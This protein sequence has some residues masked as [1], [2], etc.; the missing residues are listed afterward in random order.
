MSAGTSRSTGG[1]SR[2]VY[3]PALDGVRALAVIVVLLFHAGVP[4]FDGGYLG[5]SVFFTLSGYLITSLLV[6]E[7]DQSGRIDL[8]AFYGR[9]MRRLLPASVVTVALIVVASW[10][11][12]WFEGVSNLRAHVLGSLFQVANWV[13]L[14][15]DGSY[16][17][18]LEESAGAS[19]PLE[20]FWSLA[21]E[22]QFYW[23]W[24]MVMLGAFAVVRGRRG[25]IV[26]VGAFTALSMVAAPFVAVVWG[27]DAAY[28]ATPA[29]LAEI[30]VGAL[31][32]VV[33]NERIVPQRAAALAPA[34]LVALGACVV[35]FPTAGGPAYSGAL[36]LIAVG[37]GALL[38]G[39][40][41]EGPVREVLS[42]GVLVWIG[43]VSYGIYLFHWPIYVVLDADRAGFDGVPLVLV[44]LALTVAIAAVSYYLFELPIRHTSRVEFPPTI[45]GAA[46]A[47]SVT[48]VAAVV[49]VP[50]AL[51]DYWQTDTDDVEAAAIVVDDTPLVPLATVPPTTVAPTTPPASV[52]PTTHAGETPPATVAPAPTTSTTTTLP[53]IPEL[54][55]PVRA[56]V[57]GDS[58]AE[59]I[60]GGLISW[61]AANPDLAQVET[62]VERGC[63]VLRGGDRKPRD[64]EAVP[65]RCDDWVTSRV[66]A[67]AEALTPDVVVLMIS[68][69]DVLDRR[70]DGES[71][72][73]PLDD[74]YTERL[75]TDYRTLLAE[76]ADAGVGSV[77]WVEP[78]VPNPLWMSGTTGQA[79]PARH[80][81]VGEVITGLA[82]EFPALRMLPFDDWH[83]A[84]GYD[85][86][87]DARPDGVHW[88]P[89]VSLSISDTYLGEQVVRA[90][91][92]LPFEGIDT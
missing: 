88:T 30:L 21:I 25:Q 26:F 62:E 6:R 20:H 78:P 52:P 66:P 35:L 49:L 12:D 43:K 1:G 64:W 34:A 45:V 10:A 7:H 4:G 44:R 28:W 69:W 42:N 87:R 75:A 67:Q 13:F 16:Q 91:L 29:R 92:G 19:S 3:Q 39:L 53:P 55:R 57:V 72:L 90:A 65:E 63:G 5:V 2:L 71:V 33:L 8:A 83:A 9:R 80:A 85:T 89:E 58:T 14:A 48:A 11:T 68:S 51:G 79:D 47:T 84:V 74:E 81:A 76:L 27:A 23:V 61:A 50:T 40:Q 46:V 86:D 36:P 54:A 24:P 22:E 77:V 60:G 38:L 31:L 56:L 37:S 32:A 17:E 59:S 73:T 18:L 41:A 82:T 15:G 70:W